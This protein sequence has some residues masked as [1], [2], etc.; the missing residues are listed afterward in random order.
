[1]SYGWCN[2]R[3]P[4]KVCIANMPKYC[5]SSA[6]FNL[7]LDRSNFGSSPLS[8]PNWSAQILPRPIEPQDSQGFCEWLK[9][10]CEVLWAKLEQILHLKVECPNFGPVQDSAFYPNLKLIVL[11]QLEFVFNS[12]FLATHAKSAVRRQWQMKCDCLSRI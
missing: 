7:N 10:N 3:A 12:K 5:Q 2:I 4:M 1:M 11:C 6:H 9:H 8:L